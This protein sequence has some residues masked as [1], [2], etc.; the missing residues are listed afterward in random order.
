MSEDIKGPDQPVKTPVE[1]MDPSKVKIKVIEAEEGETVGEQSPVAAASQVLAM[2]TPVFNN[3]VSKLSANAKGRVL[4]KLI[5]FPLGEKEYA[6]TSQAEY[7]AFMIGD[8]LIAAK[9]ILITHTYNENLEEI[10][11]KADEMEAAK[12]E[13]K[14]A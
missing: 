6:A 7:D 13:K 12:Q 4:N 1:E 9:F 5:E 8:R 14:E 10:K 11:Q 2:Y 3:L